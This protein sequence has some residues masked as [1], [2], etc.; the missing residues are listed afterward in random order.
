MSP[1][2]IILAEVADKEPSLRFFIFIGAVCILAALPILKCKW[3]AVV[4][5]PIAL[6]WAAFVR[7]FVLSELDDPF[8]GP[9]IARELGQFYIFSVYG[10]AIIPFIVIAVLLLLPAK[11]SGPLTE[12]TPQVPRGSA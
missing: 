10:S 9:A 8:V 7:L 5:I 12:T 3:L 1:F 4:A 6:A 2:P 11:K